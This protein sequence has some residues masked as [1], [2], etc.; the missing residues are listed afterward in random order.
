[1]A[2]MTKE[3]CKVAAMKAIFALCDAV[4]EDVSITDLVDIIKKSVSSGHGRMAISLS[5]ASMAASIVA[6]EAES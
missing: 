1:M 2:M 4:D 5:M 6:K 3:K